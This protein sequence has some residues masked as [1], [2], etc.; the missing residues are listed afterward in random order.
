VEWVSSR[1][2]TQGW[3]VGTDG[4]LEARVLLEGLTYKQRIPTL[5]FACVSYHNL[6]HF[7][8]LIHENMKNHV[9]S[10]RVLVRRYFLH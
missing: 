7:C 9:F 6:K 4:Y 10:K 5:L 1:C 3:S 2:G 8:T